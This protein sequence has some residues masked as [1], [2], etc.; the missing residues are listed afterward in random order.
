MAMSTVLVLICAT[1]SRTMADASDGA[2]GT[3]MSSLTP[4][5]PRDSVMSSPAEDG[6][7]C[8]TT[9]RTGTGLIDVSQFDRTILSRMVDA[10]DFIG[11]GDHYEEGT[12]RNF[13]YV[14][15]GSDGCRYANPSEVLPGTAFRD[16][17]ECDCITKQN[18][19]SEPIPANLLGC[20]ARTGTARG[21]LLPIRFVRG[22][23]GG[24]ASAKGTSRPAN[25]RS[26]RSDSDAGSVHELCRRG[27]RAGGMLCQGWN[28]MLHCGRVGLVPRCCR[29]QVL[30][31]R[32]RCR[33]REV[34]G[35]RR[36]RCPLRRPL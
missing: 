24:V 21:I 34:G 10:H 29:P 1:I 7:A 23:A 14:G 15:G 5:E 18:Q 13:C 35:R 30:R 4:A 2:S 26:A 32:L 22:R 20:R 36:P 8:S 16:C 3:S 31:V 27:V 9:N 17:D 28:P 11:C 12:G 25:A 33:L 19:A 6:C